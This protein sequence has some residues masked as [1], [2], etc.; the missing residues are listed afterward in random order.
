MLEKYYPNFPSYLTQL[1]SNRD[2][3]PRHVSFFLLTEYKLLS[4]EKLYQENPA[5][6]VLSFALLV[7]IVR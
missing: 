3:P 4:L 5:G 7:L 1:K 6:K 2:Y